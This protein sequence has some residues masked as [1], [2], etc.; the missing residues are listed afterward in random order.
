MVYSQR[1]YSVDF[2]HDLLYT[3]SGLIGH[4]RGQHNRFREN[5]MLISIYFDVALV[6]AVASRFVM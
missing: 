1:S 6:C 2:W 3:V 5:V 4:G